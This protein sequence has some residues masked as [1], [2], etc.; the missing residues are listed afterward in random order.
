[1]TF[2]TV[3]VKFVRSVFLPP[4]ETLELNVIEEII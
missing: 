4:L 2:N 3:D 1:M